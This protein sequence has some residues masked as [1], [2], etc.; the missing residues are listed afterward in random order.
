MSKER[1]NSLGIGLKTDLGV[2]EVVVVI[3]TI[4]I[5]LGGLVVGFAVVTATGTIF[6]MDVGFFVVTVTGFTGILIIDEG[7]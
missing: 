7:F 6:I 3:V 2:V 5:I 4:L 1:P